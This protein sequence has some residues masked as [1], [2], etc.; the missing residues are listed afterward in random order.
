M[1][2]LMIAVFFLLV[3]LV[4]TYPV[5]VKMD[6]AVRDPGDPLLNTWI[7]NW[8]AEQLARLDVTKFFQANF[9]WPHS[10]VLAYSEYMFPNAVLA[11]PVILFSG[12]PILGYN[13]LILFSFFMNG[14]AMYILA[15]SLTRHRIGSVIAGVSYS[16]SPFMFAHLCHLQVLSAWAI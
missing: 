5:A 9:F 2:M 15:Y 1:K 10:R 4:L 7:L 16:F 11:M 6:C 8:Q 13:T 12:N 14:L 3:T